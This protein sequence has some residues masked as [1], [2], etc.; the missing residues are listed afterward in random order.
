[1]FPQIYGSADVTTLGRSRDGQL[2]VPEPVS[3]GRTFGSVLLNLFTFELDIWGRLRKQTQAVRADLLASEEA[4]K[5]V[6]TTIVSD[7]AASY[8][9]VL[10]LDLELGIARR[11]LRSREE[12]LRLIQLRAERGVS[13][14]LEVRQGDEL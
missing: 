10:E 8:F 1:Q 14:M 11:T 7:V 2:T 9:I 6:L 12:S 3:K 5:A 13:N 4:R